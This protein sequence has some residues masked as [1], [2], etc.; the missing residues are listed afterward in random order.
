[1]GP[2]V[3]IFRLAYLFLNIYDTFKVLK[4]PPSRNGGPPSLRAM[5]QRKRDMKGIMTIWTVWVCFHPRHKLFFRWHILIVP[6]SPWTVL[7]C[8][9]RRHARPARHLFPVLQRD[10]IH[11]PLL[12]YLH[13]GSCE[14]LRFYTGR[15][16]SR[17][18]LGEFEPS[19]PIQLYCGT[20]RPEH[21]SL[22]I[23]CRAGLSSHNPTFD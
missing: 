21:V 18:A 2:I 7:H 16:R 6:D 13:S 22:P 20:L 19:T 5:T 17:L 10:Q 4:I 9:V 15:G 8:D 3:P 11:L 14:W 12:L 1:M 23:G